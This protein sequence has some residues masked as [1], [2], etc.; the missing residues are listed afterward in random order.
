MH[1]EDHTTLTEEPA[2]RGARGLRAR[3]GRR[4][5][6]RLGPVSAILG[7]TL[8]I[9]AGVVATAGPASATDTAWRDIKYL[10]CWISERAFENGLGERGYAGMIYVEGTEVGSHRNPSNCKLK[11]KVYY[12]HPPSHTP[13]NA[14]LIGPMPD[15][16]HYVNA[17]Y[18]FHNGESSIK[19]L[20]VTMYACKSACSDGVTYYPIS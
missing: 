19:L 10:D 3:L 13:G 18:Y 4:L 1:T 20:K 14:I 7:T 9:A 8:L 15:G 12:D 11:M 6:R 5:G 2:G 16:G 17:L